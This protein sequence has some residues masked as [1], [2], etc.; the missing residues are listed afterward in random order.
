MNTQSGNTLRVLMVQPE[1]RW[2]EPAE[3][4]RRLENLIIDAL[5][6]DHVDLILLPET[7]TTGF[8]GDQSLEPESMDGPTLAWMKR[9]AA[10]FDAAVG[11]SVVIGEQEERFNRFLFVTPEGTVRHYDKRHLFAYGG[12]HHR[13]SAGNTRVTVGFRNWR[14]AL[15]IC[16]DLR[17][18]VWCRNQDEYDLALFV[19]NWPA[20]RASAWTALLR[21][22]AIENQAYAIGINRVGRDGNGIEYPG[23]S[24]AFD[25]LGEELLNLG[26]EVTT[27]IVE[28]DLD[29][30]RKLRDELPFLADADSFQLRT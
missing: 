20:P 21:A 8:L 24:L 2:Q 4:L 26:S 1:I 6:D 22:R 29:D 30:L 10:G 16:Y 5:G 9:L 27:G 7:F 17:F 3:N 25:G 23:L 14:I 12:E 28:L 19:A 15:N 13:Y 11:G 18:P